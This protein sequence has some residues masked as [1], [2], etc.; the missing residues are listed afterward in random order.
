[1]AKSESYIVVPESVVVKAAKTMEEQGEANS[2]FVK[3]LNAGQEF[4][5]AGLTPIY[6]F[7]PDYMDLLVI[8]EETWKKKLN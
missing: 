5:D 4:K 2:G 1:M 8:C 7:D 6:L 3:C